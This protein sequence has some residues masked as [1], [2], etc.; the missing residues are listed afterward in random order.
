MTYQPPPTNLIV[1]PHEWITHLLSDPSP[2]R[3]DA[4]VTMLSR[5]MAADAHVLTRAV[6]AQLPDAQA[7]LRDLAQGRLD[8]EWALLVLHDRIH[9]DGRVAGRS[10]TGLQRHA[11]RAAADYLA[12]RDSAARD[13]LEVVDD[14]TAH[15][16][17]TRWS[18][19]TANG[20]TRPHPW[21]ARRRTQ[22]SIGFHLA[23][24]W[25]RVRDTLDS[26]PTGRPTAA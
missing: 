8:L 17:F 11:V 1:G 13:L 16:L 23:A 14:D 18:A 15:A 10:L 6:A 19:A 5:L 7:V 26:R 2:A 20:S 21:L 24:R 4:A 9:G 25:D 3:W 22:G 12:L